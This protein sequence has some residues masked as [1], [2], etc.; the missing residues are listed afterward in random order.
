MCIF[1]YFLKGAKEMIPWQKNEKDSLIEA[2][3]MEEIY[4][5]LRTPLKCGPVMKLEDKFTDSPSI[6]CLNDCYC[7][8]FV[9]ISKECST[10]GY[11]THLAVSKDL[12]HWEDKGT[13]LERDGS[14]RWDS[15]QIAGYA[16]FMPI[17]FEGNHELKRIGGEYCLFY[18]GG[19]Q[20][21]YEPDPLY[22]GMVLCADPMAPSTYR[23]MGEPILSPCDAD[24]RPGEEKTI[25]KHFPFED[26]AR[27]TGYPYVD[28]YNAKDREDRE[29]IYL[30]VSEDGIHW[31]RYGD[32]PA[33]DQITD[34]P[35]GRICGDPQ[36]LKIGDLYVM[37]YFR[38][39]RG[40]G[41]YNTFACSRDL[42]CWTPWEGK[43]LIE[44]EFAWEDVHAHKSCFLREN[45]INYHFYC[46]VNSRN[47]RFIALAV[48]G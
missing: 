18:L 10:S 38:Y 5:K 11:E 33:L 37:L 1:L 31:E 22:T 24:C 46:A 6:F 43:P 41:A 20:D 3:V 27:A 47:E 15:R 36:I 32:G 44:P 34:D 8:Y 42:I 2:E 17:A 30:A 35:E 48:S 29:R 26:S 16:A 13:V 40:A 23:R 14:D 9:T 19:N 39:R 45:G 7:M 12:R 28:F 25:Y 21:G 4:Q